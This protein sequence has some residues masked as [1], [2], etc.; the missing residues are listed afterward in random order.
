MDIE[1]QVLPRTLE[2]LIYFASL[3][4]AQSNF[5]QQSQSVEKK[6]QAFELLIL[7]LYH[8]A[9]WRIY[10]DRAAGMLTE[11]EAELPQE[12]IAVNL[13]RSTSRILEDVVAEILKKQ[14]IFDVMK[15]SI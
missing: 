7:V 4:V 6:A 8:P 14:S 11:L 5:P 15:T 2:V 12:I 1:T 3:L 9:C 13:G 10:K